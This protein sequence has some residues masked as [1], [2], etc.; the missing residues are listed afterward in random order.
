MLTDILK[1]MILAA[2]LAV[3]ATA[4]SSALAIRGSWPAAAH[5]MK[6]TIAI[7]MTAGNRRWSQTPC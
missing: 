7:E 5:T 2:S 6:V 4:S 3:P 1:A